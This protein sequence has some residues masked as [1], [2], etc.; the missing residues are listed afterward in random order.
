VS[1]LPKSVC[2]S[3]GHRDVTKFPS[4]GCRHV[5][6]PVGSLDAQLPLAKIHI[7]PLQHRDF[8][9][10]KA[11]FPTQQDDHFAEFAKISTRGDETLVVR[12]VMKARRR[13]GYTQQANGAR[14]AIDHA[15]LDGL[16]Q[17]R[18]ENGSDVVHRLRLA[19]GQMLLHPLHLFS[20]YC[21]QTLRPEQRLE[22]HAEDRLLGCDAARFLLIGPR[23]A[24]NELVREL[25][26][27]WHLLDWLRATMQQQELLTAL[28]PARCRR[29]V[30]VKA[31]H[32]VRKELAE[33]I[34]TR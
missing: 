33:L 27:G 10:P 23:V 19:C 22:M 26:E 25:F 24:I 30:C 14:H 5:S 3:R 17:Q 11:R 32:P 16:L 28:S 31:N 12:E 9:T 15:P 8:A 21:V 2:Q 6:V 34:V 4:F 29:F 13:P 20:G 7:T 18:V 1:D